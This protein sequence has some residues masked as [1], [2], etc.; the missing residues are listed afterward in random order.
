M[1]TQTEFNTRQ[2]TMETNWTETDR[3]LDK[4]KAHRWRLLR[5]DRLLRQSK[6]LLA[7]NDRLLQRFW[8]AP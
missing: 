7:E 8:S 1:M 2:T 6:A 3:L 5:N 4:V